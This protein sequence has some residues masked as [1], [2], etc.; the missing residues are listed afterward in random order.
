MTRTSMR[1]YTI[2]LG[3]G[4]Q[5]DIF[6]TEQKI[7]KSK[8]PFW[9]GAQDYIHAA[10]IPLRSHNPPH[11]QLLTRF[12]QWEQGYAQT[13]SEGTGEKLTVNSLRN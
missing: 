5:D 1:R 2:I 7:R 3:V 11:A 9:V 8:M 6:Q 12:I 13:R 10:S 4:I